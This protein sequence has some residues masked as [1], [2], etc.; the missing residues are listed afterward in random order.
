MKKHTIVGTILSATIIAVTGV[1]LAQ[2][3]P[4]ADSGTTG[5]GAGG[6]MN[7]AAPMMPGAEPRMLS[8][9]VSSQAASAMP[10]AN[11]AGKNVINATGDEI[12]KVSKI[13]GNLVIVEVGGFLGI[14]TH[15]V[16][17][18]WS[19]LQATGI[20]DD[21]KLKTTL[22]KDEIKALPEYKE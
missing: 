12:G 2:Q 4:A 13:V 11:V 1:A 9:G 5:S 3:Q 16:A 8:P 20:G 22:T 7:Q 6:M 14:G 10:P 18:D 15:D 21:M 19:Q 17:V